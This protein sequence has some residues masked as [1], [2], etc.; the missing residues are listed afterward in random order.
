[1]SANF[2]NRALTAS[3]MSVV[4]VAIGCNGAAESVDAQLDSSLDAQLD[5]ADT[6]ETPTCGN[7]IVEA[8]EECDD[9]AANS[10]TAPDT[11]RT[12]CQLPRCGDGVIDPARG[13]VCDDGNATA[14]DGCSAD[15]LSDET[16]GNGVVDETIGEECDD[17]NLVD[18]DGCTSSCEWERQW[19]EVYPTQSPGPRFQHAMTY[20][21]ARDRVVLF[22]GCAQT[23]GNACSLHLNDTWEYDGTTWQ[24]ILTADAP[25][26][27]R[28]H[29]L[30]YDSARGVVVLFGGEGTS[31]LLNDT[32]EYDGTSWTPVAAMNSPSV[33][34]LMAM[35][36]DSGRGVVVM[37]GGLAGF[38]L[39][40]TW[41]YSGGDWTNTTPPTSPPWRLP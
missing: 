18:G 23:N 11:C 27:R 35:A 24:P 34:G 14:G 36:Y 9:G 19:L 1:M 15:C 37:F 12:D 8:G 22:G 29:T 16:C 28:S 38:E 17:G 21:S 32:W 3:L 2:V 30:A 4:V 6:G 25:P 39:W 5:G 33:R 26:A 13:E 20:D 31:S 7:D 40:D 41:E 10:D